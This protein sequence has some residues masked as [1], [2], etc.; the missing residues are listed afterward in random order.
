MWWINQKVW[1]WR[2]TSKI[3]KEELTNNELE[4]I[5][6]YTAKTAANLNSIQGKI[7]PKDKPNEGLSEVINLTNKLIDDLNISISELRKNNEQL[8]TL[9]RKFGNT[10]AFILKNLKISEKLRIE[11]KKLLEENIYENYIRLPSLIKFINN[12]NQ[13]RTVDE[14]GYKD[15]SKEIEELN[16]KYELFLDKRNASIDTE[17]SYFNYWG[18]ICYIKHHYLW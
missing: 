2:P 4:T 3:I 18:K 6:R 14:T 12:T 15:F 10:N 11:F 9:F 7:V 5:S 8:R 13:K 1:Y 17:F 16:K